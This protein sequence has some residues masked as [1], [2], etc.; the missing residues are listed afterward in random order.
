MA[1]AGAR[2]RAATRCRCSR[3]TRSCGCRAR[4][5]PSSSRCCRS[6][7]GSRT[8]WRPGWWRAATAT[9]YGRLLVF[10]FPKQKIVFG[11][12]QIVGR[13]NQDQVISPQITLWNQ[14][15]SRGHLGHAARDPDQRV[16]ALRAAAL[17]A[18]ARRPHSRAEARHRRVSEPDRDGRNADAGARRDLRARRGQALAPDRLASSATSVVL[19]AP[20]PGTRT[21]GRGAAAA[22]R[23]RATRRSSPRCAST[24]TRRTRR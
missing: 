8:T 17:S 19:T 22:R 3:T 24:T 21:G 20:E 14:Q 9:H 18:V 23:T 2:R 13:I 6:R 15:G 12:K 7:R 16:A 4:S 1:G 11:P 10:Q 5:S